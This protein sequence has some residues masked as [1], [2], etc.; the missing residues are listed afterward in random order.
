M[1]RSP[2]FLKKED[3]FQIKQDKRHNTKSKCKGL[4]LVM[5][6]LKPSH[7][8]YLKPSHVANCVIFPVKCTQLLFFS[9]NLKIQ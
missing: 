7:V 9:H 2:F 5:C 4:K 3:F 1:L 6:Y 8:A